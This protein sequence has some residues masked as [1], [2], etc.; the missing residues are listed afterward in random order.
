MQRVKLKGQIEVSRIIQGQ[1]RLNEWGFNSQELIT[2]IQ[3]AIEI[4]ITSIDQAD[5]YGDYTS[6]DL[7]GNAFRQQKGLRK[8]VEI[9]SKCGIKLLSNK[10]PNRK[11]KH[12]DYSKEYIIES[13]NRSLK[14]LDTDYI[15]ILLLHRPSPF[16]DPEEVAK[17][18]S[19]L[20]QSGKV[21]AFG[22][23]NYTKQQ[24]S[25]LNSYVDQELISNQVEISPLHLDEFNN[26]NMDFYIEDKM[27][28]MAWSPLAGGQLFNPINT[29]QKQ[30]FTVLSEV[31]DELNITSIDHVIYTWL[32][33]H[34][35]KIIPIVGSGKIERLKNASN[36]LETTM[37]IEQWFRIY[38]ASTGAELP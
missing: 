16:F 35:S 5:I 6:E 17:A 34:P 21:R 37:T 38:N 13:L 36:A 4:G 26:G 25:M 15:D 10:F 31:A 1:M 32:L 7:L 18:F 20:K 14:K 29:K 24:I 19:E 3:K 28:P 2:F 30:I 9:I 23:S 11:I 27:H 12:Y 8:E 22:V 33:I